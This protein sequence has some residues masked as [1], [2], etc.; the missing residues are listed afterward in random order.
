MARLTG[1]GR[2]KHHPPPLDVPLTCHKLVHRRERFG[3]FTRRQRKQLRS[4]RA[5]VLGLCRVQ[6]SGDRLFH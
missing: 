6:G 1:A 3:I 5:D 2:V 4:L